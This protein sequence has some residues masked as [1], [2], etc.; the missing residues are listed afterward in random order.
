MIGQIID[1][2]LSLFPEKFKNPIRHS[3]FNYIWNVYLNF[4]AKHS[5]SVFFGQLQEDRL[6]ESYF[7][8]SEGNYVDIGAGHPVLGS[9]TYF[10]YRKGW[11]GVTVDPIQKNISLHRLFRRKDTQIR[12][13]IGNENSEIMFFHIEPYEYS[14]TDSEIAKEVLRNPGV[15]LL[16]RESLPMQQMRDLGVKA[17]F[18]D[19]TFLSVDVEGTDFDVLKSINWSEYAPR[20]ICVESW[21]NNADNRIEIQNFLGEIGYEYK[22]SAGLSHIFLHRLFKI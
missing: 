12:S 2:I 11:R 13:L 8:E 17:N 4:R 18:N 7:P 22:E 9:N 21:S 19:A 1:F 15:R 3:G 20:L 5:G 6:I 10:F 16:A 14:T